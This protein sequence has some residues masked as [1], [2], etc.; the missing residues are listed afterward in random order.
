[1]NKIFFGLL[2]LALN[3][4]AQNITV[5]SEKNPS[6]DFSKY[7]S[8]YWS[9]QVDSELDENHFFVND[10]ILKS[11]LRDAVQSEF[12]EMNYVM[13]SLTPDLIINFRV[14]TKL[15]LLSGSQGYGKNYWA[16]GE[17]S[18][19]AN[20]SV[21]VQA[22]T[23]IFSIVDRKLGVLVWQCYASGLGGQDGITNDESKLR[24]AVSLALQD[25]GLLASEYTK[26]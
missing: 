12:S 3:V 24:H 2:I 23:I 6:V 22:G 25:F 16:P 5:R 26:R 10:L 7:K 14:F 20:R 4:N 19:G 21:R 9:E 17:Y 8:Y 13:E 15:T 11:D 18:S 1:M